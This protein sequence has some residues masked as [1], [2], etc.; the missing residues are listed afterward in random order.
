MENNPN[1]P[2][3]RLLT[4]AGIVAGMRVLDVGCGNGEVSLLL[5]RLVGKSGQVIGIDRDARAIDAARRRALDFMLTNMTFAQADLSAPPAGFAPVDALV[6]RRVLMYLSDPVAAIRVL[7]PGLRPGGL[8]IFQESDATMLPGRLVPM[9]L[10]ERVNRWIWQTVAREG[11]NIHMRFQLPAVLAQAGLEVEHVRAE[12]ITQ[13]QHTHYPLAVIIRAMLPRILEHG[14][15]SEAELAIDTLEQRMTAERG[16][17]TIYVSD[18][19]FGVSA[20]KRHQP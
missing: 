3:E 12:T 6:G 14:V 15:A 4:D 1:T 11:G 17:N 5:A 18:M 13:G 20:R 2:T 8:V 16:T 19:A 9:P 7:L 10:H